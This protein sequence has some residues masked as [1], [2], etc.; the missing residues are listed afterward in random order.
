MLRVSF[1]ECFRIYLALLIIA[2]EVGKKVWV[3]TG[4][5][6]GMGREISLLLAAKGASLALVDLN[7]QSLSESMDLVKEKGADVSAHLADISDR[8]RTGILAEEIIQHHKEIHGLINNAG[9]IQP[10]VKINDLEWSAIK[11]VMDV[12]FFGMVNLTKALLPNL[13][14]Q[15]E[16]MVVNV[17]SMG[18]FTPVPGQSIYGASK[19]AVKLFSEGLYAELMGTGVHV[20]TVFPG[21]IATNITENSGV[22]TPGD[23]NSSND[24]KPMA[25]SKAASL[26]L[27]GIEKNRYHVIVGSD[28]K[29]LYYFHRLS[30][31][32][33]SE[34]IAKKMRSLLK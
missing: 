25:A 6:S 12:N 13:L 16:G 3:V 17:S 23:Q 14:L 24:F 2:M 31:K 30:P 7:E 10:F 4:A 19:A 15:E 29:F 32:R 27:R 8:E 26:I 18:G 21:A 20:C 9:I 34:F 1:F 5:G 28:A 22:N 11:K 33:A